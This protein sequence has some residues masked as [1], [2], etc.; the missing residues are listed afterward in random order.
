MLVEETTV[1]QAALPIGLFKDHLR[2]GSGFADDAVQDTVLE[3]FLRAA[4]AAVEARTGKISIA[5]DFSQTVTQW[6]NG[7]AHR[8][9]LAPV[10]DLSAFV[11]TNSSGDVTEV[12]QTRYKLSPNQ[13]RPLLQPHGGA[14]PTIPMGG[15]ARITMTAGFGVAWADLPHDFAQAIMMLAA[16]FYENRHETA[17]GSQTMPFGV[18]SLLDAYIPL[19]IGGGAQV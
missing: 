15:T 12:T 19:R 1:P 2:M 16:H 4:I 5:R 7:T 9:P 10:T 17:G 11:I 8:L 18:A 13:H 14:L 6:R 3:G